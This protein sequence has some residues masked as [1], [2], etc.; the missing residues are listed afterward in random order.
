MK[1]SIR[2]KM[3]KTEIIS[4]NASVRNMKKIINDKTVGYA[5][6]SKEEEYIERIEKVEEAARDLN[7]ILTI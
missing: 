5:G 1:H 3:L 6:E 7:T 2:D 4:I